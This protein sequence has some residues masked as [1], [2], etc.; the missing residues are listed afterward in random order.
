[1]PTKLSL[2]SLTSWIKDS[3]EFDKRVKSISTSYPKGSNT[4]GKSR[5]HSFPRSLKKVEGKN[6]KYG[7]KSSPSNP[8]VKSKV[9]EI[10]KPDSESLSLVAPIVS[11]KVYP[12]RFAFDGVR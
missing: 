7:P 10:T 2:E 9:S 11:M 5:T 8:T 12:T 6:S 3:P 1:M 4:E